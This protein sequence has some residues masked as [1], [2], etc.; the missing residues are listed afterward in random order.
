MPPVSVFHPCRKTG[1]KLLKTIFPV[2]IFYPSVRSKVK[3]FIW[4]LLQK[5][6]LTVLDPTLLLERGSMVGDCRKAQIR[7]AIYILCYFVSNPSP[8]FEKIKGAAEA[9]NLPIVT[10]CGS[11]ASI[12]GSVSAVLD[13]GP[14]EFLGL[15]RHAA[16]VFTNSLPRDGFFPLIIKKTFSAFPLQ[17][18][19]AKPLIPGLI[20]Y[21]PFWGSKTG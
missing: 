14:R 2:L 7:Q 19:P 15:F 20:A 8:F 11:R 9:A 17:S 5:P 4:D 16:L 12:P 21:L 13:A 6:A 10:L 1:K 18:M 3:A